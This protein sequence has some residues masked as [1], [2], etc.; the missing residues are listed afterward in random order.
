MSKLEEMIIEDQKN[1]IK[2]LQEECREKTDIILSLDKQLNKIGG[3]YL[4]N[5]EN[6]RM[7]LKH[8][9]TA[10]G[11]D[12]IEFKDDNGNNCSLQKSS[13]VDDKIW[14]GIADPFVKEFWHDVIP[15]NKNL[16]CKWEDRDINDLKQSPNNEISI[17]SR[18][19]LTREQVK[20][21]LPYLQ[22]F[23]NTGE[24]VLEK[25]AFLSLRDISDKY[26]LK[27]LAILNFFKRSLE[28]TPKELKEILKL[29]SI[30][31]RIAC[32]NLLESLDSEL[33]EKIVKLLEEDGNEENE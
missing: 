12:L 29:I 5:D 22:A 3:N 1:T 31:E 33:Y 15:E 28:E 9:K 8:S 10:R 32:F 23:V 24:I 30:A 19:H 16:D 26:S 27:D 14:L 25:P 21:L 17:H 13:S 18:M 7:E 6:N 2:R 11:F 4:P 20:E